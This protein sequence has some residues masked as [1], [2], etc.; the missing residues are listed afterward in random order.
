MVY[1]PIGFLG[2]ACGDILPGREVTAAGW[3]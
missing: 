1:S 2:A 3:F